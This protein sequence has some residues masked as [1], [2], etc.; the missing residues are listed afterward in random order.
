MIDICMDKSM[1]VTLYDNQYKKQKKNL[2]LQQ[3][4]NLF[5]T[6]HMKHTVLQ[7]SAI[8]KLN[9]LLISSRCWLH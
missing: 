9:R 2:N 3:A 5:E 6:Q 1:W 4:L 8:S 7:H